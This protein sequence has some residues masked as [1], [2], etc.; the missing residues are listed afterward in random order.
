M[1]AVNADSN[2]SCDVLLSVVP[3]HY[4]LSLFDE[5]ILF[6]LILNNFRVIFPANS[7]LYDKK[8]FGKFQTK[9]KPKTNGELKL[10]CV[11]IKT[12]CYRAGTFFPC[13][14][15]IKSYSYITIQYIT[16][17]IFFT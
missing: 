14:L 5:I 11:H 17:W 1:Q 4:A 15:T 8:P 13:H 12:M 7:Y 10:S 9:M 6:F 3:L 2:F 16:Q